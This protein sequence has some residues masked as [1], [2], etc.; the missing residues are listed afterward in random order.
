MSAAPLAR[1]ATRKASSSQGMEIPAVSVV[2]DMNF[3]IA[4]RPSRYPTSVALP[5]A[6]GS[7]MRPLSVEPLLT[8]E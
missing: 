6:S 4:T 7:F 2:S 5:S 1:L 3:T 8:S